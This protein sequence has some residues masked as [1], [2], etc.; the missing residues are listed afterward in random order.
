MFFLNTLQVYRTPRARLIPVP[1]KTT[2]QP[3]LTV[4]ASA[5]AFSLIAILLSG[6]LATAPVHRGTGAV[7][8]SHVIL[9]QIKLFAT[10]SFY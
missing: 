9:F 7:N 1:A 8:L 4:E 3:W 10:C 5:S 2:R 6:V